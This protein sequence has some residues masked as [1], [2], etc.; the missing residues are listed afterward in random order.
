MEEEVQNTKCIICEQ[1]KPLGI[2]ICS[3]FVCDECE[4]EMVNTDVSDARYP[5]FIHQM[6]KIWYRVDA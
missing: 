6:N 2:R 1:E 5:F 3:Q 4:S